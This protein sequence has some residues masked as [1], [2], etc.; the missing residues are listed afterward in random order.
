MQNCKCEDRV[1]ELINEAS[2]SP[3]SPPLRKLI[4]HKV[5]YALHS[6]FH[7]SDAKINQD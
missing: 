5:G 4:T 7:A 6:L 3:V 1:C 2:L